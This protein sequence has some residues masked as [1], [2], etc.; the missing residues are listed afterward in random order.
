M[1]YSLSKIRKK[2]GTRYLD[3]FGYLN[4]LYKSNEKVNILQL[5]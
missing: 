5:I 4:Q 3:N 1:F 2:I